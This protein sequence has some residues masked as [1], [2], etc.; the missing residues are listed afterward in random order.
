[1]SYATGSINGVT[2]ESDTDNIAAIVELS[3]RAHHPVGNLWMNRPNPRISYRRVGQTGPPDL[4][5][6]DRDDIYSEPACPGGCPYEVGAPADVLVRRLLELANDPNNDTATFQLSN[7]GP[8]R[9]D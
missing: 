3:C 7:I 6:L 8:A 1:V 9:R 2:E 5:P 4:W